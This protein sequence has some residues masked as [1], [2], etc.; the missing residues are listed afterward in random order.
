MI[1]FIY[2][3]HG[4]ERYRRQALFSMLSL[5][6]H[7][8]NG[9]LP[10]RVVVYTDDPA[11]Y[12]PVGVLTR[13]VDAEILAAWTG[14]IK[15]VH[16]AKICVMQRAGLEF[17]GRLFFLD[18]DNY[19]YSDPV[20]FLSDWK[21]D[22]VIMEKLE[23]MLDR[24]ADLLGR[25]YRRF[26]RRQGMK[27]GAGPY[28]NIRPDQPCWNSGIIGL[29]EGAIGQ[30]AHILVL[31]DEMHRLFPKH[32]SEQMSFSI[33]LGAEFSIRAFNGQTYHWFGHGRAVNSIM[34][35]V[36][37]E[38]PHMELG[39]LLEMVEQVRPQVLNAPLNPDKLP[40]Y[41]RMFRSIVQ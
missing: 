14:E 30:L 38:Y 40:W 31:C 12:S 23:Y 35:D 25:K 20:P 8:R 27:I 3:A 4:Q 19:V 37:R 32:L 26:F 15:F 9:A 28:G 18:S 5:M 34:D 11:F 39:Q 16:R 1:N 33:V 29:P 10:H 2:L 7:L 21:E 36:L 6:G 22:T 17:E 41:S 24:P 13:K